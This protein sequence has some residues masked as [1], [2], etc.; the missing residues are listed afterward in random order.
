MSDRD[1]HAET[2]RALQ[3]KLKMTGRPARP[4]S[5]A[6]RSVL[7]NILGEDSTPEVLDA[8]ALVSSWY[9][10][11]QV[12]E[13]RSTPKE[14]RAYLTRAMDALEILNEVLPK[15]HG[16]T[17]D[18]FSSKEDQRE[19]FLSLY[20]EIKQKLEMIPDKGGRS[21]NQSGRILALMVRDVLRNH[22]IKT[23]TTVGGAWCQSVETLM[24][25]NG[26]E[27]KGVKN[28]LEQVHKDNPLLVPD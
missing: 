26:A 10:L 23:V 21:K 6:T 7:K 1:L 25:E 2:T 9:P 28:L 20:R 24:E 17:P 27:A 3:D 15:I 18:I 19:A 13:A 14:V 4:L 11:V 22:G 12:A 16:T 5:D 8:L